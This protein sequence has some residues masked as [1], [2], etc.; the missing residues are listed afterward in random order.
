MNEGRSV[1][2]VGAFENIV[3]LLSY[4]GLFG[5]FLFGFSLLFIFIIVIVKKIKHESLSNLYTYLII[6]LAGFTLSLLF[7]NLDWAKF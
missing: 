1:Y 4:F 3:Y 5:A 2:P 7:M 6:G